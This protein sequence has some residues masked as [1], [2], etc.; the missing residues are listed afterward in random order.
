MAA[1]VPSLA[2]AAHL[3]TADKL[4]TRDKR[5]YLSTGVD[6]LDALL[7]GGWPRGAV[8]ELAGPRGSGRTSLLLASLAAAIR[9]GET[10][11]LVDAEGALCPRAAVR[12]GVPLARL[13]WVR[14]SERKALAAAEDVLAA[15]GFGLVALD[16]GEATSHAP[17]ASWRRLKRAAEQQGSAVLVVARRRAE[18]LLG[19]C[20]LGLVAARPHFA[21]EDAAAVLVAIDTLIAR[22]K[23]MGS[24]DT[25]KLHLQRAPHVL[26]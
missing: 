10:V 2:L 25:A 23:G 9:R 17:I 7:G 13:L 26:G 21:G 16:L 12:A 6:A 5:A 4:A 20:A 15:G 14:A 18:G 1:W 3:I 11:A 8:G 19:A 22:G 24:D